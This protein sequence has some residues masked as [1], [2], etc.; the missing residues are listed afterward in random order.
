M[1]TDRSMSGHFE[2][3]RMAGRSL[4]AASRSGG[5]TCFNVD[6]FLFDADRSLNSVGRCGGGGGQ[7]EAAAAAAAATGSLDAR[8]P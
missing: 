1:Q 8:E 5:E 6:P 3:E 2:A 7:L 4:R